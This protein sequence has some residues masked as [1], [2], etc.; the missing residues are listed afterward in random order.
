MIVG[1]KTTNCGSSFASHT[2]GIKCI[3]SKCNVITAHSVYQWK[4]YASF[5]VRFILTCYIPKNV[6]PLCSFELP[7]VFS[8]VLLIIRIAPNYISVIC[9]VLQKYFIS[10]CRHQMKTFS[11]PLPFR[12]GNS[13]VTGEFPSQRPAMRS[14]DVFVD[15]SQNKRLSKQSWGWWFETSSC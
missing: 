1:D 12:V 8:A 6:R 4:L 14:F 7:F 11:V 9:H 13:P 3:I 10:W 2:C 5:H 15:L